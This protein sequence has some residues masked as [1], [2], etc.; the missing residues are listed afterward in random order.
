ML[1]ISTVVFQN[2]S[3]AAACLFTVSGCGESQVD[4]VE[5]AA[6][7]TF[8][9]ALLDSTW[10][11]MVA[12]PSVL[13]GL[14]G[15]LGWQ[16]YYGRDYAT[17]LEAFK[18]DPALSARIHSE[19]AAVYRNALGIQT[20]SIIETYKPEETREGDPIE[21]GYLLGVSY[22]LDSDTEAAG[23]LLGQFAESSVEMVVEN[24]AS[25]LAIVTSGQELA[26]GALPNIAGL[27]PVEVGSIPS[28]VISAPHFQLPETVGDRTVAASDPTVL[29]QL[30]FWHQSAAEI[31]GG[32]GGLHNAV[33]GVNTGDV[34]GEVTLSDLFL[35]PWMNAADLSFIVDIGSEISVEALFAEHANS[36]IAVALQGCVTPESVLLEC[37]QE[38]GS[39][40]K[41]AVL[42]RMNEVADVESADYR[43]LAQLAQVG[44]IRAAIR[45]SDMVGDVRSSGL[46]R[47]GAL[48]NERPPTL[49]PVFQLAMAAWDVGNRNPRRASE[50]LHVHEDRLAG[51]DSARYSLD[52]LNLR[53]SRDAG[54]GLPMH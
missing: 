30:A 21:T 15:D 37:A 45:L 1:R 10:P 16:A 39:M 20:G 23:Q 26:G 3:I 50:L 29:A 27:G 46:L 5:E 17:A 11:V 36:I 31:A 53:V 41:T 13:D 38:Q 14:V 25:W 54:A 8:D 48:E 35:G 49:D 28:P 42:N 47:I 9:V 18:D 6:A 40:V 33:W 32:N 51:L 24:D 2:M 7:P 34:S 4:Q 22:M 44:V 12:A 43:D 52:A 19:I